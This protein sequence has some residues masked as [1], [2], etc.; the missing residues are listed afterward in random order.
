MKGF[1]EAQVG[2]YLL[3]RHLKTLSHSICDSYHSDSLDCHSLWALALCGGKGVELITTE[4]VGFLSDRSGR[5]VSAEAGFSDAK[6]N[7]KSGL[8]ADGHEAL[9]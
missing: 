3:G 2:T 1:P 6:T 7:E 9:G 5:I 8:R 4:K